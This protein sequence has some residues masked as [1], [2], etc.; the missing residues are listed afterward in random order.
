NRSQTRESQ[1]KFARNP[2]QKT[3]FPANSSAAASRFRIPNQRLENSSRT[4]DYGSV[5]AKKFFSE[6]L[7]AM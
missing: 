1:I 3:R 6:V 4:T 5:R 7:D 2:L